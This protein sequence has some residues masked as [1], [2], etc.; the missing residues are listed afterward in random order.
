MKEI[1]IQIIF[2]F[3]QELYKM[4]QF[5]L[6]MLHYFLLVLVFGICSE[7]LPEI[8]L[9]KFLGKKNINLAMNTFRSSTIVFKYLSLLI[10]LHFLAFFGEFLQ[11]F[12]FQLLQQI[13]LK[14]LQNSFK[15]TSRSSRKRSSRIPD[16]DQKLISG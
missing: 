10:I 7:N 9:E 4:L 13:L 16:F 2:E 15:S 3:V 12:S 14:F 8:L 11:K 6:K 5:F 1:Q